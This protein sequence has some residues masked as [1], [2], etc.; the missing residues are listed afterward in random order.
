MKKLIFIISLSIIF[1]TAICQ[2]QQVNGPKGS[3]G[4]IYSIST[5]NSTIFVAANNSGLYKSIDNGLNW[6]F[7]NLNLINSF[8]YRV[9]VKGNKVL[10]GTNLGIVLSLDLGESWSLVND[11]LINQNHP[12]S[13]LIRGNN[14]FAGSKNG[15]SVSRDNGISWSKNGQPSGWVWALAQNGTRIFAGGNRCWIS[16]DEGNNWTTFANPDGRV[17]SLKV[18]NIDESNIFYDIYAGSFDGGVYI[19]HSGA[20]LNSVGLEF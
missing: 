3:W 18:Y 17:S 10:V 4:T 12:T 7:V 2:W 20:G 9:L 11:Q 16:M 14:M 1:Q 19:A 15:I 5:D 13:F 6:E 8:I